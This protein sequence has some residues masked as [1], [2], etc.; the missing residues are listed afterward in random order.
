[1]GGED[2][3]QAAGTDAQGNTLLAGP[4]PPL[5]LEMFVTLMEEALQ[6]RRGP[7]AY[8]V[9]SPS[10]KQAPAHTFRPQIDARS[11]AMAAKLR[12][13]HLATYEVLHRVG[14]GAGGNGTQM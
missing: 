7:R 14:G 5:S 8:L 13:E 10:S 9:P 1:V 11:K 3:S 4:C 6:L 12:P 2:A